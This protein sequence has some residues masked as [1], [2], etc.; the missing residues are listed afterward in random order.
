MFDG[1]SLVEISREEASDLNIRVGANSM[2]GQKIFAIQGAN[3]RGYIVAMAVFWH[4]DQGSYS[5]ESY[6]KNEFALSD[7]ELLSSI[8]GRS[9][10]P[11]EK[12]QHNQSPTAEDGNRVISALILGTVLVLSAAGTFAALVYLTRDWG[13]FVLVFV[14]VYAIGGIRFMP[15]KTPLSKAFSTGV[16]IAIL[17]WIVLFY[18]DIRQGPPFAR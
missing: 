18:L 9:K 14:G 8:L 12:D 13:F 6:F 16:F 5:D 15:W 3:F 10:F 4:E 17:G 1:F 11:L 2:T 7:A